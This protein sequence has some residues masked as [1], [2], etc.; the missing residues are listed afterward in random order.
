MYKGQ[1]K[2]F[3]QEIV[4][5]ILERQFTY[6]GY[7]KTEMFENCLT[8]SFLFSDTPEG[9][10]F[11][12]N[13]IVSKNFDLFFQKYPKKDKPYPKI[14]MV[15]DNPINNQNIGK[16]RVV[17]MEKCGKYLAWREADTF[18]TAEKTCVVIAWKYAKDIEEVKPL[19]VTI[20]DIALKFGVDPSLIE[21]IK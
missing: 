14:M 13:V 5:K 10:Q 17:F 6:Y 8:K 2:D 16:P 1:I 20:D 3:P 7:R 9:L 19:K 15:S 12:Y 4:E 21:I 18:E 11:W